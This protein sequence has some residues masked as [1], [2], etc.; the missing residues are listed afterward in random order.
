MARAVRSRRRPGRRAWREV[1]AHDAFWPWARALAA[2]ALL[3]VLV[4]RLDTQTLAGTLGAVGGA[5]SAVALL[6]ALAIGAVT[7]V[8]SAWRWRLVAGALG[9]RLGMGRAL[10]DYYRALL[11]NAVLPTGVLGDVHRAVD[12]G[13]SSGDLGRGVRAV[14]LE[15]T[16]GQVVLAAAGAALLIGVPARGT[17]LAPGGISWAVLIAVAVAALVAAWGVWGRGAPRWRRSVRGLLA[18]ARS[19][20][21]TRDTGPPVILLSAAVLAGHVALFLVAA[22]TVGST[23]TVPELLPPAI[24]ALLAMAVPMNAAGWGPR[25]AVTAAAFGAAGLGAELGLATAVAYGVLALAASLPG[26]AVLLCRR[27]QSPDSQRDRG[28]VNSGGYAANDS[29]RPASTALPLRAEASEGRP[30]TPE[31]V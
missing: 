10:A 26:V 25:E 19:A 21:L 6:A 3:L 8:L 14:L 23:A 27:R 5:A 9:L 7:T 11:L 2:V 15:R 31:P 17:T 1:I 28:T 24:L 20:L 12:H 18:D 16:A 30:T 22:W 13:R 4:W 29:T